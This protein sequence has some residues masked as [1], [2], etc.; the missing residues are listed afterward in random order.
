MKY[1]PKFIHDVC[2]DEIMN[3]GGTAEIKEPLLNICHHLT[4]AQ[5]FS[6]QHVDKNNRPLLY[7]L[8]A[9]WKD[10]P[11]ENGHVHPANMQYK[12]RLASDLH[13][14]QKRGRLLVQDGLEVRNYCSDHSYLSYI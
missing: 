2:L 6:A 12:D 1:A 5:V 9:H 3:T 8:S 14:G 11:Q 7:Y 10:I 4:E 13:E